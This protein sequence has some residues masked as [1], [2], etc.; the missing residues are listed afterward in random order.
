MVI[1]HLDGVDHVDGSDHLEDG[2]DVPA[3]YGHTVGSTRVSM[4]WYGGRCVAKCGDTM[5]AQCTLPP[6]SRS[7]AV[8]GKHARSARGGMKGVSVYSATSI[9]L[10]STADDTAPVSE[11]LTCRIW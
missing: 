10:T 1:A 2:L 7:P 5:S 3:K 8:Y 4:G 11:T 6:S 9:P